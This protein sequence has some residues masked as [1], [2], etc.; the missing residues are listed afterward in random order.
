MGIILLS[1]LP[2]LIGMFIIAMFVIM[3]QKHLVYVAFSATIFTIMLWLLLQLV[4]YFVSDNIAL[5]VTRASLVAS[6]FVTPLFLVF[7]ILY[8]STKSTIRLRNFI[9][10]ITPAVLLSFVSFLPQMIKEVGRQGYDLI[11][12][13][14]FLYDIQ[15]LLS[16]GYIIIALAILIWK[17]KHEKHKERVAI[18]MLFFA[19]LIPLIIG[20]TANYLWIDT[21]GTQY[22]LPVT[23]FF[24]FLIIA[25]AMVRHRLFDIRSAAVRG[26][27]YILSLLA[28]AVAYYLVAFIVS[29]LFLSQSDESVS[30]L[31]IAL[32]LML[33]FIFQPVKHFFDYLT[34]NIFFHDEYSTS[35]FFARISRELRSTTDLQDLLIRAANEIS[36]TVKAEYGYFY[37]RYGRHSITEGT[38]KH[39]F[40]N[41]LDAGKLDD[42]F[43]DTGHSALLTSTLDEDTGLYH[44]LNRHEIGLVLALRTNTHDPGY[45]CLGRLRGRDYTKRD[46]RALE[47]ISDQLVIAIQNALSV[48][49]VK[50]INATLQQRIENATKKLRASNVQLQRLDAAKD[51]FVSMASHQL[52]TPLTSVKGYISMVLE[53]DVGKITPTQR[54]LLGEAFT[55]SER[56]VHLINDFLNVSRIQTGKFIVDHRPV[57]LVKV[58]T[59]EVDSLQTTAKARKLTLTYRPPSH[60][61]IL[62]VDESKLRQVMMN[63][64]DN[65]IYY[66]HE[67]STITITLRVEASDAVFQVHDTGIGIPK[68]EQAHI[69][70]KF[71]RATNARKQR[72]DGTG[73][74][75]FLAKKIIDA[76]EGT[77]TLE[78]VQ[79]QGS[80]FGF[81]L[82]IK[83][84]S[85]AP[86]KRAD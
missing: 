7:A 5:G 72:P 59:Q 22:L 66:S 30:P 73:V 78:S 86:S 77:I 3:R 41:T 26:T 56:M 69:F 13:T 50:D 83:K 33:A 25:Y 79:D 36:D 58:V 32:A 48:Q 64:I 14:G 57:D 67:N 54:R 9:L 35:D 43:K 19:F 74:G 65:A 10:I 62:Y 51:E 37:L 49:E 1:Y 34:N 17:Y 63:F 71:F 39:S 46:L 42:Y 85:H 75:L 55:S 24:T 68:S 38:P 15:T 6:N 47:T 52:R 31:S 27:A 28:L 18:L 11:L 53:G 29:V 61:P 4:S 80:T 12:Q 40:I 60:F 44:F 70:T 2:A 16:V 8:P 82:P 20:F 81:R 45:L 23:L 76:H 21:K 84:L